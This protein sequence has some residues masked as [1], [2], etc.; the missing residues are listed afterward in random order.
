[1]KNKKIQE[2]L[3][4]QTL[5]LHQYTGE[6][7]VWETPGPTAMRSANQACTLR[8]HATGER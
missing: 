7:N 3:K 2:V 6:N 4:K 1:M 8:A 5:D